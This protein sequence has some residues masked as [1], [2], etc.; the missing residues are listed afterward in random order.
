MRIEEIVVT[1]LIYHRHAAVF[2]GEFG[3]VSDGGADIIEHKG[4]IMLDN[5][6][7]GKSFEQSI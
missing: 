4:G 6:L 1:G 7:R 3:G 5:L 2:R